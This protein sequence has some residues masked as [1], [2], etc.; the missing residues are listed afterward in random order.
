MK[1]ERKVKR[2]EKK[3]TALKE[4]NYLLLQSLLQAVEILGAAQYA[5]QNEPQLISINQSYYQLK[6]RLQDAQIN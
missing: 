1:L 2:L 5:V 4:E 3:V 6:R